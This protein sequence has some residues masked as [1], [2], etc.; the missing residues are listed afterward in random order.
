LSCAAN[1]I[2]ETQVDRELAWERKSHARERLEQWTNFF[3][4]LLQLTATMHAKIY[5]FEAVW[6]DTFFST[7]RTKRTPKKRPG[8]KSK[9]SMTPL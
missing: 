8:P 1:L 3:G 9:H 5:E 4:K 2:A 6:G 7:K